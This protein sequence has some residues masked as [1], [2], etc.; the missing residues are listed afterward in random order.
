MDQLLHR[1]VGWLRR[2]ILLCLELGLLT[3]GG[4]RP[5]PAPTRP[6]TLALLGDVMLGRGIHASAESFAYLKPYLTSADLAL[7]NLESP[8]T[9][10]SSAS[11][12]PYVLCAP[13]ESVRVLADAGLDLLVLANN[14]NKDCGETGLNE[15]IKVLG[16]AGI[17]HIGPNPAPVY[18]EIR[19]IHIGFLAF[20]ATG[21]FDLEAAIGAVRD[22][23]KTGAVVIV[24]MHW[25]AE[26]QS[27][28]T[29][30]QE[31]IA[32]QLFQ[33]GADLI[34]GHHPHVL[35]PVVWLHA[36]PVIYSL[37]NALFDQWGLAGTRQSALM[38]VAVDSRRAGISEAIPFVID[39][40]KSRIEGPTAVESATIL[41]SL[42]DYFLPAHSP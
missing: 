32:L 34:W 39:V 6:V 4:C 9:N 36:T 7:A 22:V 26:Y 5:G 21:N 8:L 20:D 30:G 25:G 19:G 17:G 2:A 13:P 37:G 1:A 33:A 3:M 23:N 10:A 41:K 40:R 42:G 24:S 28:P 18:R 15:T 14:H 16:Q 29:R 12:S 31:E 35:Q 11:S 27:G 38:L